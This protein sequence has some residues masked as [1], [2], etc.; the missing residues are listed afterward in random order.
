MAKDVSDISFLMRKLAAEN[1]TIDF[2]NYGAGDVQ[3]LYTACRNMVNEWRRIGNNE[4][5]ER[6][7]QVLKDEDR[8]LVLS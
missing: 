5:I 4:L 2:A 1:D 7:S 6:M 8:Q 3:R